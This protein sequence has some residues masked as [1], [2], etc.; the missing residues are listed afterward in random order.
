MNKTKI[1]VSSKFSSDV[2]VTGLEGTLRITPTWK[3]KQIGPQGLLDIVFLNDAIT[4]RPEIPLKSI[5]R[6]W[7]I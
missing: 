5:G 6:S 7:N 2:G 1:Y 3:G 4:C